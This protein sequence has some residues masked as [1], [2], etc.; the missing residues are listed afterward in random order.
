MVRAI[1]K[2]D[3]RIYSPCPLCRGTLRAGV[4]KTVAA[5]RINFWNTIRRTVA[6]R[7]AQAFVS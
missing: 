7:Y 5:R 1:M 6:L 3:V 4:P 2:G